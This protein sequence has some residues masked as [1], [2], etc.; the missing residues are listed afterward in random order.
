M[1]S[2]WDMRLL[3]F[4]QTSID[5]R[6][7]I[8][9]PAC[10]FFRSRLW[11]RNSYSGR[12]KRH[13]NV[14]QTSFER[15][16]VW[17]VMVRP[18]SSLAIPDALPSANSIQTLFYCSIWSPPIMTALFVSMLIIVASLHIHIHIYTHNMLS[19]YC[20]IWPG[21]HFHTHIHAYII[22]VNASQMTWTKEKREE[23][24]LTILIYW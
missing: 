9:I 5:F 3:S 7:K 20:Q 11:P 1:H 10:C 14:F 21:T 2:D 12:F 8:D 23:R 19:N 24:V 15:L 16:S 13:M 22:S 17:T 4:Y 6:R 18:L